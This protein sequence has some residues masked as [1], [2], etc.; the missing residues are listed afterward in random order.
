MAARPVTTA[1]PAAL[2]VLLGG[3][4]TACAS[5]E[6]EMLEQWSGRHFYPQE[7]CLGVYAGQYR[8]RPDYWHLRRWCDK[9]EMQ[10]DMFM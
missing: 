8:E 7:Y 4:L 5:A 6:P 1:L 3:L 2:F 9:R 10:S